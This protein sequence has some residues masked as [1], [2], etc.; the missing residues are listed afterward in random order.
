MLALN[1][2]CGSRSHGSQASLR[3]DLS[4]RMSWTVRIVERENEALDFIPAFISSSSIEC[5]ATNEDR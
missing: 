4:V 5:Q 2:E 1:R 3:E